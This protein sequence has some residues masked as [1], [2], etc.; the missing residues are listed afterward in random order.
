MMKFPKKKWGEIMYL[1][2]KFS[3]EELRKAIKD[4]E[5]AA[6]ELDRAATFLSCKMNFVAESVEE[7]KDCK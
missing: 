2:V 4:V 3:D 5:K 6:K 7:K 1:D